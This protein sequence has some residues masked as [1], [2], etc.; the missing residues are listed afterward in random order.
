MQA[1]IFFFSLSPQDVMTIVAIIVLV[2][3]VTR[4]LSSDHGY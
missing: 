2:A 3:A 1:T 4:L